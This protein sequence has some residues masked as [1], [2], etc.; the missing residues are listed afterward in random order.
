MDVQIKIRRQVDAASP[1]VYQTFQY[2]GDPRDSV[3]YVLTSLNEREQ[4]CDMQGQ[5]ASTIR[6]ECGCMQ[7]RCG[8]CAMLVNGLPRL[9]CSTF[10][11]DAAGR[12]NTVVLE[13]LGKFPLVCDLVVDKAALFDAIKNMHL[14]LDEEAHV[15]HWN[16]DEQFA[17]GRCLMCGCCLEVCPNFTPDGGFA[18]AVG[19]VNAYRYLDQSRY[20]EHRKEMTRRYRR[21]YYEGCGKSLACHSICPIK[22]PVEDLLVKSNATAVWRK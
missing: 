4:L 5:P 16:Q 22:L 19:A 6:W 11:E 13:P 7:K 10:L 12:K 15:S 17:S 8:A 3:A 9:A 2:I 20:G 21:Y 18:G 14:W 1:A